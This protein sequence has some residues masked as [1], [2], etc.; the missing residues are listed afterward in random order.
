MTHYTKTFG[1]VATLGL[2]AGCGAGGN[3]EGPQTVFEYL[4]FD[5]S[6]AG[7]SRLA[8]VGLTRTNVDGNAE[9]TEVVLGTLDR[10]TKLLTVSVDGAG[11]ITGVFDR[12][13]GVWEDTN[14]T[15]VVASTAL[16]G[17]FDFLRPVVI[18]DSP[19]PANTYIL[20]VVTQ[21][22]DLPASG[23]TSFTGSA[24]VGSSMRPGISQELRGYN[25]T[26]DLTLSANFST[27]HVTAT[28]SSLSNM[29]FDTVLIRDLQIAPSGDA[30]FTF[31]GGSTIV[32]R[33]GGNDVTPLIGNIIDTQADGAFFGGDQI[34]PLEAG[35]AFAR[36][37]DDG[38]IWGIFVA[39]TR[40]NTQ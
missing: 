4:I 29:P 34:G 13:T 3:N 15:T 16:T 30:T 18:E 39:D 26:G 19:A 35:G 21:N 2:L 32:F 5:S 28:I 11:Q 37:G 36:V 10:T 1:I 24:V 23:T 7:E 6:V 33:R 31:D 38:S 8:A 22:A 40:G 17:T 20:G 14:G 27:D 9:G 25:E 12:A